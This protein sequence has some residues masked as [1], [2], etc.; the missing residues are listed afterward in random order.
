MKSIK[1]GESEKKEEMIKKVIM[2]ILTLNW[3]T[4]LFIR[5]ILMLI[6]MNVFELSEMKNT[7]S[8]S[9]INAE[10]HCK[11]AFLHSSFQQILLST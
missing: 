6:N 1:K 3:L 11:P 4:P 8:V 2:V 5:E 10:N 9:E 7:N